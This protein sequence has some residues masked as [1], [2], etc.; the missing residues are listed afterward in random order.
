MS[1][2]SRGSE[3][4]VDQAIVAALKPNVRGIFNLGGPPAVPL[5]QALKLLGRARVSLPHALAKLTL[6]GPFK[7]KMSSFPQPELDF[8]RYVCMVDDSLARRQLGY[9][10]RF[11]LLETLG[12][13]DAERWV[14]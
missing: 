9:S 3:E 14:A 8:I 1:G 5:S 11:G 10:P 2:L 7:A 12:S 6:D 4:D 13:V